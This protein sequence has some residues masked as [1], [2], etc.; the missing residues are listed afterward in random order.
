MLRHVNPKLINFIPII[1]VAIGFFFIWA[2]QMNQAAQTQ[3]N[4]DVGRTNQFYNRVV[5]CL[6]SE[7]PA[8]RTPEYTKYCYDT[9]EQQTG[10]KADRYGTAKEN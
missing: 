9:V 10:V 2:G 1:F 3:K 4:R 6:A 8:K 7:S 5:A